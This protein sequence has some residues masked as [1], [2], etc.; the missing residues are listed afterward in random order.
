[1]LPLTSCPFC[2]S[3]L[4]VDKY[5]NEEHFVTI[6][7]CSNCNNNLCSSCFTQGCEGGKSIEKIIGAPFMPARTTKV[8]YSYPPLLRPV[9]IVYTY[10]DEEHKKFK[11]FCDTLR[12]PLCGS[13]LDGNVHHKEAKL[14]C[15]NNNDE[16]R[17]FWYPDQIEPAYECLKFWYYPYEYE[18]TTSLSTSLDFHTNICKYDMDVNPIHKSS[19]RIELFKY[20][21]PRILAFRRRM[22]EEQFLKKLKTIKVFS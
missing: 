11:K 4:D 3:I 21:G 7:T 9:N 12:C 16:Y 5:G 20:Q 17:C 8:A 15:V 6:S 10:V 18:I 1:M 2:S 22:E 14:Y 13:Q 19:T